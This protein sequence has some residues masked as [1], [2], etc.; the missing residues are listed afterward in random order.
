MSSADGSVGRYFQ[1]MAACARD[2]LAQH[3]PQTPQALARIER[4]GLIQH[5]LYAMFCRRDC[6]FATFTALHVYGQARYTFRHRFSPDAELPPHVVQEQLA[7]L[8]QAL[9]GLPLRRDLQGGYFLDRE[10][11]TLAVRGRP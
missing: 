9:A 2:F 4:I 5:A 8:E 11:A 7:T 6:G 3:G 1:G 10:N